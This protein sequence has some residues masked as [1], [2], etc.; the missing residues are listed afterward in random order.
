MDGGVATAWT[1]GLADRHFHKTVEVLVISN[2]ES[3]F[4]FGG[5]EVNIHDDTSALLQVRQKA[6]SKLTSEERAVLG[7]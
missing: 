6:L 1:Q 7:L 4:L 3:H 5:E 2:G